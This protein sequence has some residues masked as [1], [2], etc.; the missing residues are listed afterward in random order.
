M[1]ISKLIHVTDAVRIH[2]WMSED[3]ANIRCYDPRSSIA[4]NGDVVLVGAMMT[5]SHWLVG[6]ASSANTLSLQNSE[7]EK[8][9]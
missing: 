5:R 7:Q 3:M 2:V 9:E 8:R 4:F 6:K 1:Q